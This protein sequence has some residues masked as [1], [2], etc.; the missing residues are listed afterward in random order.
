ME[1]AGEHS[2][3]GNDSST[4]AAQGLDDITTKAFDF[5]QDVTKQVLTLAT[6]IIALTIT[7]FKNFANHAPHTAEILM[8]WSW[9]AYL[10]SVVFGLFT[11][12]ALTGTLQPVRP[13]NIKLSIQGVNIRLPALVQLACFFIALVLSVWAGIR[14]L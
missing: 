2:V 13:G 12:M 10:A 6:G 14:T 4:S 9:V 8:G 5:A 11:L 3:N 7:F 1:G